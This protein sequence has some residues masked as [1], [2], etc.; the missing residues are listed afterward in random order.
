[1]PRMMP[2][3]PPTELSETA[4]IRNWVRMSRPCAPTAIRDP[5]LTRPFGYA[6]QHDVH[7]TDAP[8]DQRYAGDRA[9]QSS[10]DVGRGRCRLGDF[11]LIA[12]GE[13]VI[14]A[15]PDVVPLAQQDGDLL[16]RRF[17]IGRDLPPA[18]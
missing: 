4:S 17:E 7:D 10:H 1:M 15:G 9:E 11:L 3:N 13:I 6:D 12:H 14:A 16:L 18:H 5:D 2:S 8:N